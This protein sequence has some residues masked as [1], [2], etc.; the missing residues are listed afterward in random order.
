M[1][2]DFSQNF[3]IDADTFKNRDPEAVLECS[4]GTTTN[5]KIIHKEV[6]QGKK[7][8]FLIIYSSDKKELIGTFSID[9]LKLNLMKSYKL[10][11]EN[12][13]SLK[14]VIEIGIIKVSLDKMNSPEINHFNFIFSKPGFIHNEYFNESLLGIEKPESEISAFSRVINSEKQI[15]EKGVNSLDIDESQ[16][17]EFIDELNPPKV[18]NREFS[19]LIKA[20]FKFYDHDHLINWLNNNTSSLEEILVSLVLADDNCVTIYEK[21]RSVFD[22]VRLK[23]SLI[24]GSSDNISMSKLK[25][26]VY[27]LYKRFMIY[28]PKYQVDRMIDYINNQEKLNSLIHV[29]E[30][31]SNEEEEILAMIN[32]KE[33]ILSKRYF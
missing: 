1:H 27:L 3:R 20:Y 4:K 23:N 31:D 16:K 32:N 28:F 5:P 9:I 18:N 6:T 33:Y 29:I 30:Y 10:Q 25:E 12:N 14:S 11:V 26:V 21:L 22:I 13:E 7:N 24:Y 2:V 17:K 15:L 19:D 8:L